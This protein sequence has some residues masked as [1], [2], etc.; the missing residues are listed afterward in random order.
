MSGHRQAAA[1]LHGLDERDR[2]LILDQLPPADQATL[3]SYLDELS[4]LGFEAAPLAAIMP[5]PSAELA[6]ASALAIY[7]LLEHE[8]ATLVAQVLAAQPWRWRDELLALCSPARRAAIGAVQVT[9]APVLRRF[10]LESLRSRLADAAPVAPRRVT[11]L[12]PL[13]RWVKSWRQ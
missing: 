9:A 12:T 2:S 1:A 3:R 10:L 7:S 11:P 13:L 4:A 6:T 8:P 5:A